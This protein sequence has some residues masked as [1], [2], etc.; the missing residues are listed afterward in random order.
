MSKEKCNFCDGSGVVDS[1]ANEY[2]RQE[3]PSPW[4]DVLERLPEHK[5]DRHHDDFIVTL[6]YRDGSSEAAI[7]LVPFFYNSRRFKY[8]DLVTAWMPKPSP[9]RPAPKEAP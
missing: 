5:E 2:L 8:G 4:V 7:D 9:Y 3:P 1:T 6:D